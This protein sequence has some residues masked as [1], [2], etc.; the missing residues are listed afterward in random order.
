MIFKLTVIRPKSATLSLTMVI[1]YGSCMLT[2]P[3]MGTRAKKKKNNNEI[4]EGVVF[5]GLDPK[6]LLDTKGLEAVAK[7][8]GSS[9]QLLCR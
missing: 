3:N 8:L 2:S 5:L 9:P 6:I 4:Q 7:F 1:S